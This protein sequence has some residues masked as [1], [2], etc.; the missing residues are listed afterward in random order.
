MNA[1]RRGQRRTRVAPVVM[2]SLPW[3]TM[4]STQALALAITRVSPTSEW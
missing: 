2:P 3:P 1:A 4:C